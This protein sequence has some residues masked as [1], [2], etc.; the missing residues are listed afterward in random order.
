MCQSSLEDDDLRHAFHN[1]DAVAFETLYGRYNESLVRYLYRQTRSIET[2]EDAAQ[3]AWAL[4]WTK[5]HL[6][7][8]ELPIRVWLFRL[9]L[10]AACSLYR[11]E[12]KHECESYDEGQATPLCGAVTPDVSLQQGEIR[13]RIERAIDN[14]EPIYRDVFVLRKLED[15]SA[16]E[17][18]GVLDLPIGTVHRRLFEARRRLREQ[19]G[20]EL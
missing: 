14:L 5:A 17:T 3:V 10:N 11:R 12:R 6:Y 20:V 18:A 13:E 7:K 9:G 16:E 4:A 15:L 19:L 1:R 8:P 2:A